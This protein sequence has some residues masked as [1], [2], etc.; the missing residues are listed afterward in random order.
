M[1][2]N[3]GYDPKNPVSKAANVDVGESV[4]IP[5]KQVLKTMEVTLSVLGCII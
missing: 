2:T 1:N 3:F 4:F 5:I